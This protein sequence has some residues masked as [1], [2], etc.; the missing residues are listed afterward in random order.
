MK[1]KNLIFIMMIMVMPILVNAE[2]IDEVIS[3][4]TLT[5]KS[6]PITD[7]DAF[8]MVDE[9][10]NEMY[11]GYG[12][13]NCNDDYTKCDL[14][15]VEDSSVTEGIKMNYVYD[16][17]VKKVAD[18]LVSKIPEDGIEFTLS[19][20]ETISY[21]LNTRGDDSVNI[22]TYS[23]DLKKYL[24]Y[25]NF[26]VEPRMGDA[27]DFYIYQGGT[28]DFDY[29]GTKYAYIDG[30][31]VFAKYVVYIDENEVNIEEAVKT[32]LSKFFS[33]SNV[34]DT[35]VTFESYL[36]TKEDEFGAVYDQN[37]S[38]F[39]SVGQTREQYIN[40]MMDSIFNLDDAPCK[41]ISLAEPNIYKIEFSDGYS[42]E[43]AVVKDS[44]KINDDVSLTTTDS[45]NDV[46]I[47]T[48]AFLPLDTLIEVA[49]VTSGDEYNKIISLLGNNNEIFDL[50]LF[51]KSTSNYIT[52][53]DNGAFEVRLPISES[54][55]GKDLVVY[56][57]NDKNELEEY[58]VSI[59][60]NYAVF[61]TNHFSIYTLAEK[62]AAPN[63][64]TEE[65]TNESNESSV[66][67]NNTKKEV[68]NNVKN[69]KTND[70]IANFVMLFGISFIGFTLARIKVK[71]FN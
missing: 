10:V 31:G 60:G 59:D 62:K 49:R 65:S 32:R 61:T 67:K 69:P 71:R 41:F 43:V 14:I 54:L 38:Y 42:I 18:T 70:N 19:D 39:Q 24:G 29:Q 64:N 27:N 48:D 45:L 51:S 5:I 11:E 50:K 57:V 2:N 47:S 46:T 23:K 25:K 63:T 30:I 4:K 3:S 15:H 16:S 17:A 56:F 66:V 28:A 52:V 21:L 7:M 55:K 58:P 9:L 40:N 35:G 26:T 22:A 12:L 37:E 13:D 36:E 1:L 44:S 8:Y 34:V 68:T 20:I 33:I 6:V 53:L